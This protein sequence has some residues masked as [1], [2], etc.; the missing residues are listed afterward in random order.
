MV[1]VLAGQ[2]DRLGVGLVADRLEV[3]VELVAGLGQFLDA[4]VRPD[5]LVV[6]DDAV[7]HEPWGRVLLAVEHGGLVEGL[8]PVGADL[9][10]EV[11]QV[12]EAAGL[13]VGGG[14]GVADLEDVGRV[15]LGEGGGQLLLD[16]VPLLDLELD[17]GLGL[18]LELLG[19]VRLPVVGRGAV[20]HPHGE[21]LAG[22]A[23]GAGLLAVVVAVAPARGDRDHHARDTDRGYKLA[24]HA[25]PPQGCH[26]T[27]L[28][29]RGCS[30][31]RTA[32]GAGTWTNGVDQYGELGP[33]Q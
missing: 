26:T 30:S 27:P 10:L 14:L 24:L 3:V 19:E 5:L 21:R 7:D 25:N 33:D 2:V 16:A 9:A 4:R 18:R 32:H 15:L 23:V 12:R 1:P 8:G 13:G 20:H 22:V 28:P 17:L 31:T 6:D 11:A 29:P